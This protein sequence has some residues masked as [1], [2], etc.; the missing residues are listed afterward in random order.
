[1]KHFVTESRPFPWM[2]MGQI[3]E[4]A[5]TDFSHGSHPCAVHYKDDLFVIAFT[6]RDSNQRS[7]IF[8]SYATVAEG[9]MKLLGEPKLALRYGEPGYFDCDGVI[10]VCFV[11][12]NGKV[13]LY[14]VGWQNLPD[15]LWIC[16]TGR[17]ILD[18]DNLTLTREFKRH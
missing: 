9:N 5:G 6:R 15:T 8:L 3:F 11:E 7:H 10:S 4:P 14:Y 18:P 16:D 1:M 13:Y 17:V 12:H 2:K